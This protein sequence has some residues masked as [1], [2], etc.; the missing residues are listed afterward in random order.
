[1][2]LLAAAA[3]FAWAGVKFWALRKTPARPRCGRSPGRVS[4]PRLPRRKY[5]MAT[6]RELPAV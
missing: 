6:A 2:K 1:M 5:L 3:F 4:G